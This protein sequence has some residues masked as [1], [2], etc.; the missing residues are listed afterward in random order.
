MRPVLENQPYSAEQREQGPAGAEQ[1]K[2]TLVFG[3]GCNCEYRDEDRR[4]RGG[5]EKRH[6]V[7]EL[8]WRIARVRLLQ[9]SSKA[10]PLLVGGRHME[11]RAGDRKGA[12]RAPSNNSD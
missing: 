9:A 2:S 1:E 10:Y 4:C 3:L 12:N 6:R 5:V 7:V 8:D 11:W